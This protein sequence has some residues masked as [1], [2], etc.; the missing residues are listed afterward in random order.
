MAVVAAPGSYP[1]GLLDGC[2]I[3]LPSHHPDRSISR[4]KQNTSP[5]SAISLGTSSLF[6]L[7]TYMQ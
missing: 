5:T 6:S 7:S 2:K 1:A 3:A 4:G